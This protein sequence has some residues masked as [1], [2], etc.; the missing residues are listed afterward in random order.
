LGDETAVKPGLKKRKKMKKN[1]E[2]YQDQAEV[3]RTGGE[4]A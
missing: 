4:G 2:G 1:M 3:G